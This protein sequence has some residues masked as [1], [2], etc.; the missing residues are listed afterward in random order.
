[1]DPRRS[2]WSRSESLTVAVDRVSDERQHGEAGSTGDHALP[3]RRQQVPVEHESPK[4]RRVAQ[5]PVWNVGQPVVAEMQQNQRSK[6]GER[7]RPDVVE[8]V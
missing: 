3:Q 4:S 1:V 7:A 5:H 2:R 6:T 8:L